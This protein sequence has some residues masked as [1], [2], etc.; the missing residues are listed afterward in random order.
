MRGV[1]PSQTGDRWRLRLGPP[2]YEI[3]GVGPPRAAVH[4]NRSTDVNV[5]KAFE[6]TPRPRRG[7]LAW[8]ALAARPYPLALAGSLYSPARRARRAVLGTGHRTRSGVCEAPRNSTRH[9]LPTVGAASESLARPYVSQPDGPEAN[10]HTHEVTWGVEA[11][12][13]VQVACTGSEPPGE[14][15]N[16]AR[17]VQRAGAYSERQRADT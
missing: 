3:S 4:R 6:R 10:A 7:V 8:R 9:C 13:R 15:P 11:L 14:R 16:T 5:S 2:S 17:R 1:T 12:A